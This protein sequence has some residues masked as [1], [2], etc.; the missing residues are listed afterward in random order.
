MR[1]P[2]GRLLCKVGDPGSWKARACPRSLPG[3]RE[4]G[5]LG[6]EGR[7][8]GGQRQEALSELLRG[9]F[10]GKGDKEEHQKESQ[11]VWRGG[12]WIKF[13]SSWE[14]R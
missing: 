2:R 11:C 6:L 12:R 3:P 10:V 1:R 9:N 7:E 13:S 4:G 14:R 5:S 8:R